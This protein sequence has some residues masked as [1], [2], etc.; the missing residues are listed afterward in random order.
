M[1]EIEESVIKVTPNGI[2]R[3]G[4]TETDEMQVITKDVILHSGILNYI[5]KS[6]R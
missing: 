1:K 5:T 6:I 2:V 3:R 4:L